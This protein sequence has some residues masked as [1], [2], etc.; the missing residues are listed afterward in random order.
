MGDYKHLSILPEIYDRIKNIKKEDIKFEKGEDE[1]S[2][3]Y[4]AYESKD[5]PKSKQISQ[6]IRTYMIND[7]LSTDS[8][9]FLSNSNFNLKL[10]KV[11]SLFKTWPIFH[12]SFNEVMFTDYKNISKKQYKENDINRVLARHDGWFYCYYGKKKDDEGKKA[13]I[14]KLKNKDWEYEKERHKVLISLAYRFFESNELKKGISLIKRAKRFLRLRL[15]IDGLKI[16]PIHLRRP[17]LVKS[18]FAFSSQY[19][20]YVQYSTNLFMYLYRAGKKRFLKKIYKRTTRTGREFLHGL[21][22]TLLINWSSEAGRYIEFPYRPQQ[23][24]KNM[25][26]FVDYYKEKNDPILIKQWFA[27]LYYIIRCIE[28]YYYSNE[29]FNMWVL[30]EMYFQIYYFL[31][32][33]NL[34]DVEDIEEKFSM[35]TSGEYYKKEHSTKL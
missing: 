1:L 2:S 23:A 4:G 27:F 17:L 16:N 26:I 21:I 31:S 30:S 7:F 9:A 15:F 5:P 14:E 6:V 18:I 33:L 34:F 20:L 22:R 29:D 10:K 32:E 24:L 12:E 35:K 28:Q 13:L 25:E 19:Y 11:K 8:T 3:L